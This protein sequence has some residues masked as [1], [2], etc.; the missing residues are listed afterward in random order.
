MGHRSLRR[1]RHPVG[2]RYAGE[3]SS[4]YGR[5]SL[6]DPRQNEST[7][8]DDEEDW[9]E[10]GPEPNWQEDSDVDWEDEDWDEEDDEDWNDEDRGG[11]PPRRFG[12]RDVWQ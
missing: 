11:N 4:V 10:D 8:S 12:R 3:L 2:R 9:G 5:L 1:A 7:E 6:E